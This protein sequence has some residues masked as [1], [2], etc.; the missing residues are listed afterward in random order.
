MK[1]VA[2]L[3]DVIC[4]R[5]E[6]VSGFLIAAMMMIVLVDVLTRALFSVTS[7]FL[8]LTFVGG[9]ELVKYSLLFSIMYALPWCVD[10]SQVVVDLF[11]D[12]MGDSKKSFIEGIYFLGYALLGAGMSIRFYEAIFGAAATGET[13]QDLLIPLSYI[14]AATL[15]GSVM[16]AV[17]SLQVAIIRFGKVV[18]G[19]A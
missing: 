2:R 7:G 3:I 10:R 14:Y 5:M 17:R 6:M 16:L 4:R 1:V 9:I 13:T 12:R 15:F 19:A 18:G 8:D 11:T